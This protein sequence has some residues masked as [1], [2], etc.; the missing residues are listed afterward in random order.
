MGEASEA[1]TVGINHGGAPL[2]EEILT[3]ILARLP[4][5]SVGRFRCVSRAWCAMLSSAYFV[6]LHARRTNRPGLPRLLLSPEGSSYDGHIYSWQPGGQV[7]KLMRYDL[8][9]QVT[10]LLTKPCHGLILIWCTD[11]GGYFVCNPS[12]GAVLPLPDSKM[13]LKMSGQPSR[14]LYP[15]PRPCFMEVSYGLGYCAMRKEYKVVRLFTNLEG[16]EGLDLDFPPPSC[17]VFVLDKPAYWRPTAEKPPLCFV[18]EERPAVFLESEG[19]LHFLCFDGGIITFNV[20]DETFGSLPPP[21]SFENVVPVLT[22]L[23]GCLCVCYGEPNSEDPYHVYVLRDYKE[24]RWEKLCCI[25]RTAW[26]ESERMLLRSLWIA[27]LG[28]YFSGDAQKIL[29]G[30]GTCKVFAIDPDGGAPQILLVPDDTII[31]SCED[32]TIPEL[33]SFEESLVSVVEPPPRPITGNPPTFVNGKIYWMAEPNLVPVSARCEIVA[34]DVKSEEFEVVLG[35]P[36]RHDSGRMTILQLEGA[37]CVSC[38]DLRV[39]TI[40]IWMMRDLGIWSV[41]YHIE[42]QDFFSDH[43]SSENATPLAVDPKDERILLNTGCLLGYYEPKTATIETIYAA[44]M[45]L[46]S[47]DYKFC[48]I[49]CHES[50]VYPPA[51]LF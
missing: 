4:T 39:N 25:D 50:L 24:V 6:D 36:C 37:L 41:E 12:T 10:V 17:E 51:R 27:P 49:I 30:T 3:D 23:D 16:E 2:P 31:G 8:E 9:G 34:F 47:P 20:T 18:K 35:P 19:C 11:N 32:G 5:K 48:P 45:A 13:P 14:T 29:F 1:N 43:Y 40:D 38:S 26:P 7:E 21:P 33:G 15:H 42:L 46:L 22:E 44:D 28:I